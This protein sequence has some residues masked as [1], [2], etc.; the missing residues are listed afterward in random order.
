MKT[1]AKE[2]EI[3]AT[4]SGNAQ[5]PQCSEGPRALILL[6]MGKSRFV[7]KLRQYD[8]SLFA[9]TEQLKEFIRNAGVY[10]KVGDPVTNIRIDQA[11][12]YDNRLIQVH[13]TVD[14]VETAAHQ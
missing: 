12:Y 11:C 7:Q 3:E 1:D 9:Q 10:T 13:G 2:G 5:D 6:G 8:V 4:K 14:G